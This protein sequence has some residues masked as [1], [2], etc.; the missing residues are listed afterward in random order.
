MSPSTRSMSP[1]TPSRFSRRPVVKLSSARTSWPS[2]S[3]RSTTC[4]PMKPPPP[5]TSTLMAGP[6]VTIRGE[7]TSWSWANDLR[8]VG[9]PRRSTRA[10]TRHTRS[11]RHNPDDPGAGLASL[12]PAFG[13]ASFPGER[14]H[15]DRQGEQYPQLLAEE[16]GREEG[17]HEH[18]EEREE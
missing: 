14:L 5:V 1:S 15:R 7:L 16:L 11:G 10:V 2:A 12:G 9:P 6:S 3:S 18:G 13:E 4:E 17:R 8:P